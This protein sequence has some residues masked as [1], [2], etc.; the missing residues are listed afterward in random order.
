MARCFTPTR[1]SIRTLVN[2]IAIDVWV[3]G[4]A[5]LAGASETPVGVGANRVGAALAIRSKTLVTFV[6]V[7]TSGRDFFGVV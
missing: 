7:D 5:S 3:S 4:V 6:N 1:T 2:V